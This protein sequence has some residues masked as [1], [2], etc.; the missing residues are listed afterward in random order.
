MAV[1]VA[2]IFFVDL[3][4]SLDIEPFIDE[5]IHT[6]NSGDPIENIIMEYSQHPSILKIE[7][8]VVI[9]DIFSVRIITNHDLKNKIEYLDPKKATVENDIPTKMP[10]MT[11]DISAVFLTKIYNDSKNDQIFPGILKNAD[12]FVSIRKKKDLI[13]RTIGLLAYF[14]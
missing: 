3:I 12:I 6:S 13:K 11:K 9:Q 2:V 4:E 14:H 10:K 7:E 1:D 5:S 8:R